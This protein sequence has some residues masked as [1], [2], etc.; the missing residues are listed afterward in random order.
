[1]NTCSRIKSESKN[2]SHRRNSSTIEPTQNLINF[3]QIGSGTNQSTLKKSLLIHKFKKYENRRN[4]EYFNIPE[5]D[6][7]ASIFCL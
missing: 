2:K 5:R 3:S 6:Q 1:M 4:T 7:T